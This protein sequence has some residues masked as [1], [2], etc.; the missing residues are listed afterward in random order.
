MAVAELADIDA[1]DCGGAAPLIFSSD[2]L[3]LKV[4]PWCF[5]AVRWSGHFSGQSL[6]KPVK[7]MYES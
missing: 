3:R 7:E 2:G 4:V 6:E 5:S 1:I